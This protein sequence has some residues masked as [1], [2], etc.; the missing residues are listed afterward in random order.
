MSPVVLAD[1]G[2]RHAAIP[3]YKRLATIAQLIATAQ[4]EAIFAP[5]MA[6]AIPKLMYLPKVRIAGEAGIEAK[7]GSKISRE[8]FTVVEVPFGLV[9]L[10]FFTWASSGS[11]K[12]K[13]QA[14][15]AART[16]LLNDGDM[17]ATSVERRVSERLGDVGAI[18]KQV[19][20]LRS[21]LSSLDIVERHR[22]AFPK[23]SWQDLRSDLGR[24]SDRR[25]KAVM[26]LALGGLL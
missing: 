22:R 13:V 9:T 11:W 5:S 1:P 14:L 6:E 25:A 21:V 3:H 20:A 16:L 4:R 15:V 19:P 7:T 10:D 18:R 17:P 24:S 23:T 26:C 8:R 12:R 2:L